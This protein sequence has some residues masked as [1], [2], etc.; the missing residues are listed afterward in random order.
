MK[1]LISIILALVTVTAMVLS[2]T[3]CKDGEKV[4]S[5]YK[6]PEGAT[7]VEGASAVDMLNEAIANTFATTTS[8]KRVE[9]L[10]FNC[11]AGFSIAQDSVT[12]FVQLSTGEYFRSN[13][14][15]GEGYS[16]T[17]ENS[18]YT[19]FYYDGT[20]AKRAEKSGKGV[21]SKD[22]LTN[23]DFT[24]AGKGTVLSA[25]ETTEKLNE[26]RRFSSYVINKNT[27][28]E[29]HED[30]KVYELNGLYY[31][32]VTIFMDCGEKDSSAQAAVNDAVENGT[33]CNEGSV[34]WTENTVINCTFIK[35]GDKLYLN[36]TELIENYTGK[37][38]ILNATVSQSYENT[39]TYENVAI[40]DAMLAIIG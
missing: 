1:K 14:V 37:Q 16:K 36:T 10:D 15:Y 13:V 9:K 28:D 35:I 5:N 6:I 25:T 30:G 33:G 8:Y 26:Y 2:L 38:A 23:P 22:S 4:T 39:Y 40:D 12:T 11:E 3:A 29:S 34:N 27:V 20:T 19:L 18:G 24:K 21:T 17:E 7:L 31:A 32:S